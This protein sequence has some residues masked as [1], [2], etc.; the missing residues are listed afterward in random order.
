MTS[1]RP[2]LSSKR[3]LL[4]ILVMLGLTSSILNG[5]VVEISVVFRS[6]SFKSETSAPKISQLTNIRPV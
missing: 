4:K 5:L 2:T 3:T 6:T 1:T